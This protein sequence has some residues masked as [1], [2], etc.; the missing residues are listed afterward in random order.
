MTWFERTGAWLKRLDERAG[1][2]AAMARRTGASLAGPGGAATETD[3]R[4]AIDRCLACTDEEACKAWLER[5]APGAG[6]PAFCRNARLLERLREPTK[7]V[8]P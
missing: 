1:L 3:L 2:F 7:A 5:A 4:L 6:P 8:W